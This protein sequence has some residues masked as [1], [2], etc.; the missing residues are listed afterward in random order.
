MD[1]RPTLTPLEPSSNSV[2]G[3]TGYKASQHVVTPKTY[4]DVNQAIRQFDFE[5]Q[6][7]A[8]KRQI[9]D[10]IRHAKTLIDF[11]DFSDSLTLLRNVLFKDSNHVVAIQL[12]ASALESLERFQEALKCRKALLKLQPSVDARLDLARLYYQIEED[13]TAYDLYQ[14]ALNSEAIPEERLFELHK[15]LGNILV[16]RGDFEMAEDHFNRAFSKEPKSDVLMVNFGTLEI[17]RD[18][19]DA[20]SER[21]RMALTI[22]PSNDRA[23]VGLALIHRTKGDFE[24]SWGN[25]ERALDLAPHNRTALRLQVEWAVRDGRIQSAIDRLRFHMQRDSEDSEMAFNLTKCLTL[26]GRFDE[27]LFECERV[28]ALDPEQDEAYRLRRVL[29]DRVLEMEA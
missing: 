28:V 1:A 24:L 3:S 9:Q 23:W 16:R 22:N 8:Q 21:F 15:N 5:A 18:N 29:A 11:G 17:N 10:W 20:A 14:T 7:E 4:T 19:L 6:E 12:M 25:L 13:K 27:A 26:V 2:Q